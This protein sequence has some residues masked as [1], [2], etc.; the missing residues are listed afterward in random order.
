MKAIQ[1]RMFI[2]A[3][4]FAM[5]LPIATQQAH[6]QK[7]TVILVRHAEKADAPAADPPL[8]EAGLARAARL[9]EYLKNAGVTAIYSTQFARTQQTAEGVAKAT[10]VAVT[11]TPVTRLPEYQANI[12]ERVKAAKGGTIVVVGHSNT[13]ATMVAALGAAAVP[14]IP[15][16]DYDNLYIVTLHE[17]GKATVI[18]AKF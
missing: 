14:A 13:T 18:R 3:M 10:G 6:A 11:T 9:G 17:D 16:S 2:A 1:V 15:E 5:V 8:T 7:T 12:I 4:L